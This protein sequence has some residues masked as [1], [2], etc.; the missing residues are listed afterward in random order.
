MSRHPLKCQLHAGAT[1]IGTLVSLPSPEVV[2]ILVAAGFDWLF[3]D[4]E[5]GAFDALMAQRLI[6]AARD[7]PCL[8][9]VPGHDE[10]WIKKVLDIGAAGV[11]VPQVNNAAQARSIV[12]RAKYPPAGVR[13]VGIARAHG[14]GYG[15]K[16][17]VDRA[18]DEL[19]VVVQ[20]EHK[21]AVRNI[22]SIARVPGIDAILVGPYDLSASMGRI[23]RVSDPEV[24]R[25]IA[26][27]RKACQK[28][29][30]PLGVFGVTAEAVRPWMA[31]GFT[32]IAAGCDA[33]FLSIA[34][35]ATRDA[36]R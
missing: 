9:R 1:L 30:V 10:V 24:R 2:E 4:M 32:L 8:V 26:K 12:A 23:G 11:I 5:H 15:F 14:Y 35:T 36:L 34:A 21:L 28:A 33:V 18:N 31:Q 27:V 3:I 22:E 29:R 19:A 6:Q 20:A 16:D 25:A 17:Y 7:C 13:G